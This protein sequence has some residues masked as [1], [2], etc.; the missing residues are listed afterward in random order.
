MSF[1][2]TIFDD[3]KILDYEYPALPG[4]KT[5]DLQKKHLLY[6]RIDKQGDAVYLD[7]RNLKQ[8]AG[9]AVRTDYAVDFVC[10]AF[11]DLRKNIRSAANKNQIS[12]TGL[13]RPEMNVYKA[14]GRG[15]LEF[16][17]NQYVNKIYTT[18]VDTYLGSNRK[19][20]KVKNYKDFVREFVRFSLENIK[21]FPVTK[22]G[23]ITSVHC[24]PFVSGLML[25]VA[26]ER[27]GPGSFDRALEYIED[28]NF[29]FF[30]NEVKKF[31]FMVDKN[32]PWRIVFNLASGLLDQENKQKD[33]GA[34]FY[35]KKQNVTYEGVFQNHYRKA[36]LDELLNIKNIMYSLYESFYE[37]FGTY[38]RLEYFT[39]K[40]GKC[41]DVVSVKMKRQDREAPPLLD[42]EMDKDLE[43]EYWLKI[44]LKLRMSE[45]DHPHDIYN[46]DFFADKMI[47]L[48]RL[49]G[50]EAALE[51]INN[52]TKGFHVTKF[53]TKGSYW[54]GITEAEYQEKLSL[55]KK[56]ANDPSIV[57]YSLTGTKNI[58]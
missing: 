53:T 48:R 24:S 41:V 18:F 21:S 51:Y 49:F 25:E 45:T 57:S 38:E 52:L 29:I 27:H 56:Y 47:S 2:E 30:V 17:Y 55:A 50:E 6:G 10:D 22:T 7:D 12:T 32:A 31:G 33:T 13:Y 34:Q 37:Q 42:S 39:D 43:S 36:H 9:A 1:I 40:H 8:L 5:F 14:Y 44:L 3:R 46:F 23:Y 4:V 35:M 11:E 28:P 58:K 16:H 20:E 19:H 54:Y 26:S 15:D